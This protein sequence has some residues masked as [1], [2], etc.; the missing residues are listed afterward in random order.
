M[1]L[2]P[3]DMLE[4]KT[5]ESATAEEQTRI[6][7]VEDPELTKENGFGLDKLIVSVTTDPQEPCAAVNGKEIINKSPEVNPVVSMLFNSAK[8]TLTMSPIFV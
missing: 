8:N 5:A 6:I 4:T 3:L 7:D 1:S 2:T